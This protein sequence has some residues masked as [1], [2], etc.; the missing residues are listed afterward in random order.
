MKKNI[1]GIFAICL[2]IISVFSFTGC[3]EIKLKGGPS[4]SD[5]VTNNGSLSVRYGDYLYFVN[6]YVSNA[7]LSGKDN[8]YGNAKNGAI[9]R[10]K[11]ENGKLMYDISED[12]DGEEVKTLKN[13]ELLVPKIAGFEYTNLF[14]Y[15]NTIYFTSPHTN[16]DDEGTIRFDLTDVLAVSISGGKVY[17]IVSGANFT[18]KDDF[19]VTSIDGKTIITYLSDGKLN[20][21]RV[22][23][24]KKEETKVVA[25]SVT[26]MAFAESESDAGYVYYTRG[27]TE[28]E[29][30]SVGN[31]MAKANLLTG[32]ESILRKDNEN[33][34]KVIKVINDKIYY[35]RTNTLIT[36]EY[37][38][39]KNLSN[40]IESEEKQYTVVAYSSEQYIF[41]LGTGYQNGVIVNENSKLLFLT[42]ISSLEN[43]ITTLFEGNFTVI[44][45]SGEYI[46]GTNDNGD[47]VRVNIQT[48]ANEI[49]V[50]YDKNPYMDGKVKFDSE[51]GY[52]YY[53]VIHSGKS[54]NGYYLHRTYLNEPE[55]TSELVGV[56]LESHIQ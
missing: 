31:V 32:E 19:G 39:S 51:A 11:L 46:Y 29:K 3:G 42:G 2:L 7:N 16:K 6:G 36:N 37:I 15:D 18:S 34:Y 53:F 26:S 9:Y 10:A 33:T 13:V 44:G 27:F 8:N 47:I 54:A 48:K 56:V 55:K 17:K 30:A 49:I 22:S 41:D 5:V 23:K 45:V 40:F 14:I 1:L 12:E 52:I 35:T 24:T 20:I 25:T 21:V 43:D 28:S 38:Y 4:S 50:S